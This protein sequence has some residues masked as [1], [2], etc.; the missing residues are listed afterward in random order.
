LQR[1]RTSGPVTPEQQRQL[2]QAESELDRVNRL[3]EPCS[4]AFAGSCAAT[5]P[6][7]PATP[8][9]IPLPN[10]AAPIIKPR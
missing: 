9:Q 5:P 7:A 2:L 10:T 8:L 6:V 3:L 4:P 1:R